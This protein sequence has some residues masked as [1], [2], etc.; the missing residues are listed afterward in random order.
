MLFFLAC[1][2]NT[3]PSVPPQME[4]ELSELQHHVQRIE[5]LSN[6]LLSAQQ[7]QQLKAIESIMKELDQENTLLQEKKKRF[8][9]SLKVNTEKN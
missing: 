3:H 5:D 7:Q 1:F 9:Q 4:T 2:I 6:Q 8:L